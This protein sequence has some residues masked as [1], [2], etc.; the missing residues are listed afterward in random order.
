MPIQ[1]SS[2][3][4]ALFLLFA[5]TA[6]AQNAPQDYPQWRGKT[7]DG[8]ASAF[9]APASWPETLKRKWKVEVGDGYAT[10]IVVGSL[11]YAFTRRDGNEV[12]TAL[13]AETGAR[14]WQT[15]YAAPYAV[16][17]PTAAHG[18]GPKATPVFHEGK[19]FTLGI[20]GIVAAFDAAS[21]RLLWRTDAPAEHPYFSAASSPLGDTGVVIAHPGNYG[22]LTAFDADT[23]R[24]KW[25]AGDG[26]F[27]ASPI[28]ATLAG[29]RQVITVTQSSV[30][31]VSI[32][33]GAVLWKYPWPG[34]MGGTM[35]VLHGDTVIVSA[36]NAGV[37]AFT[38]TTRDGKWTAETIWET[39]DVSMY[40]SNPVVIGDTLFGL[41]TRNSGQFFAIDAKTGTVL[42]LGQP[43]QATNTAVVKAG[44]LLFLLDDDAELIVARGSRTGFEPLQRYIV[45]DSATW[46]QPAISGNRV[47]VKDVTSLTLW[48]LP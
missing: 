14:R 3:T 24:V 44:D 42:W 43:R 5:A 19:L 39:K 1:R 17:S 8:S 27:F 40:I 38:P 21:G 31:G 18:A 10:P 30:I 11:V 6:A 48:T 37:A 46:A 28:V 20:S 9:A 2:F 36:G 29:A 15:G 45:A 7:R 16:T 22:P 47:F 25:T 26:G 32:A 4:T 41:S 35:P 12:L 23:G 13:D 33:D 34:G